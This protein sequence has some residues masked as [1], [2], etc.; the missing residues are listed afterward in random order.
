MR[1]RI[2]VVGAQNHEGRALAQ[3]PAF[4]LLLLRKGLL[5]TFGPGTAGHHPGAERAG[6]ALGRADGGAEIHHRLR[7][8]AGPVLGHQRF[9][10]GADQ[11]LGLRQRL[12]DH[13]E[14]GHHPL[15][16]AVHRRSL[17]VE[18]DGRDRRRRIGADAGKLQE[19]GL[20]G[21][22]A[23]AMLVHNR[24]GAGMEI[25]GAG[26]IAEPGPGMHDRLARR[27]GEGLDGREA[28]QEVAGN[29]A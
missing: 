9:R 23:P 15:H 16:I 6:R 28:L 10:Q 8:V 19:L 1:S 27:L 14:A 2:A 25:A 5:Q 22:E 4:L 3:L 21:R 20:R 13:E 29:R 18:G 12:L 11:G 7:E 26:I 17:L 24:L